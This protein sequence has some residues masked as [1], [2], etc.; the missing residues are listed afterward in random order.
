TG[1]ISTNVAS[2]N[3]IFGNKAG[4]TYLGTET[5]NAELNY[6]GAA[7]GPSGD[8]I[9]SGDVVNGMS[10]GGSI[11]FTPFLPALAAGTPCTPVDTDGDGIPDA[12]DNCPITPNPGQEDQDADGIGDACDPDKD[13]D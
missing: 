13:G 5:I 2:N 11:D 6:W 9:G 3:N 8:G 4:A 7:T 12:T 1:T 10:G